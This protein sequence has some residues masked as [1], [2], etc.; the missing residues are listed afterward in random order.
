M[1]IK[2]ISVNFKFTKNLGNYESCTM[3]AGMVVDLEDTEGAKEIFD[4][5]WKD[6]KDQVRSQ[7][8]QVVEKKG[9]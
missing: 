2:E 4:G 3:E 7:I 9:E 6:V 5:M 1:K 8:Q